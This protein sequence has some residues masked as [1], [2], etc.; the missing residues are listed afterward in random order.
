MA[1]LA[2]QTGTNPDSSKLYPR[3]AIS[4]FKKFERLRTQHC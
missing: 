4:N 1:P 3:Q 2:A